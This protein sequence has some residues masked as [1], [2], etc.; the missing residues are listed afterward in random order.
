MAL[1]EGLLAQAWSRLL[2]DGLVAG[3]VEE[4]IV[5]PGSRS[6]PLVLAAQDDSR[7]TV[8]VIVDERAAAFFALGRARA[9]GTVPAL[10]RTSGSAGGH[11]LP[12]A[13]EAGEAGHALVVLTADRPPSL[14]GVRSPQTIDQTHLLGGHGVACL[15]PGPPEASPL[16]LRAVRRTGLQAAILAQGP[17]PGAVQVNLPFKKPLEPPQSHGPEELR[18]QELV[19]ELRGERGPRIYPRSTTLPSEEG[20]ERLSQ[21]VLRSRRPLVVAGPGPLRSPAERR[22]VLGFV[23]ALGAPCFLEATSQL[24][25][26]TPGPYGLEAALRSPHLREQLAPD[27]VL[28]L[29]DPPISTGMQLALS[30]WTAPAHFVIAERGFPDPTSRAEVI[31][32]HLGQTLGRVG[33][34]LG[35][36]PELDTG[37][38]ARWRRAEEASTI[39]VEALLAAKGGLTEGDIVRAARSALPPGGQLMVGNS[40]PVRHLDLYVPSEGNEVSVLH[41]RG[42]SG[43][44]GLIAG[45]VA[46]AQSGPCLL[47]LGDVSAQHDLGSLVLGRLIDARLTVVVINNGGGRIFE[48]LPLARQLGPDNPKLDAFITPRAVSL[49]SVARALGWTA[50]AVRDAEGLSSALSTGGTQPT[51]IEATVPPHDAGRDMAELIRR[52]EVEALRTLEEGAT[53]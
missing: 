34:R 36:Q 2:L 23:R 5:S 53:S 11:D 13:I 4:V 37:Y 25:L 22:M 7:L 18:F 3:G 21:A 46:A 14:Q 33:P 15:N 50:H 41:Q 43:I 39:A 26:G 52:V 19:R 20:L 40:L 30:E 1:H 17:R 27:L 9:A 49:V 31:H 35:P 42:A 45:A 10:I 8:T 38:L 12:A 16:A 48:Q 28:Q 44:D 32:G 24:R 6:T 29:G 51:F 47:V